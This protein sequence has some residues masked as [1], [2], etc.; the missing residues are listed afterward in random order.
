[1]QQR[2]AGRFR[3][4]FLGL[5]SRPAFFPLAAFA[6]PCGL[7][8]SGA[9]PRAVLPARKSD[10][11]MAEHQDIRE[12]ET[13]PAGWVRPSGTDPGKMQ[14]LTGAD[15]LETGGQGVLAVH[16]L[17]KSYKE[18]RVVEDISMM[19]RRGEVIGLLGPNGAGKTTLFYMI[20]GLLR[21]DGGQIELDGH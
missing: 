14:A 8:R 9:R 5:R 20:T 12:R 3:R 4:I 7:F 2:F 15:V 10:W 19:V 6:R 11:V 17:R 16:H 13:G 18:R 21:P 1:M